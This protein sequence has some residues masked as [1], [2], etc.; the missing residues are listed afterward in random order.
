MRTPTHSMKL[1][2]FHKLE[3]PPELST[4]EQTTTTTTSKHNV[5]L[6]VMLLISYLYLFLLKEERF[7]V[8]GWNKEQWR[9]Q[10]KQK[11]AWTLRGHLKK[12]RRRR[13]A[14]QQNG[15]SA[16]DSSA[17]QLDTAGVVQLS[18]VL[19]SVIV[20]VVQ[21]LTLQLKEYQ[22]HNCKIDT[23]VAINVNC[24]LRSNFKI[25]TIIYQPMLEL[26]L[27]CDTQPGRRR[28]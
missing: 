17:W 5:K 6:I 20:H 10:M 19:R 12:K 13:D 23:Q 27:S 1:D 9:T 25:K 15:K 28:N 16:R 21:D 2:S 7:S 3:Q 24:S 4:Y 26:R 11:S 8:N 18:A 22:G 14:L